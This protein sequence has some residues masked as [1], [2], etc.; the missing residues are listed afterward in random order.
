MD[1]AKFMAEVRVR[2]GEMVRLR[3]QGL[4]LQEIGKKYQI[5]AERVR[6]ILERQNK[7]HKENP[8][9]KKTQGAGISFNAQARPAIDDL[10]AAM[11]TTLN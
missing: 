11:K 9:E 2:E 4:T 10:V 7:E 1:Y 5:T 8:A 6:Q 3:K